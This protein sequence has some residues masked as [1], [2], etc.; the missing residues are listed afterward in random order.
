MVFRL[1]V[2][3]DEKRCSLCKCNTCSFNKNFE[4]DFCAKYRFYEYPH[5]CENVVEFCK[6][7]SENLFNGEVINIENHFHN[8]GNI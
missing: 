5:W 8:F 1:K 2:S 7:Y 3:A 6:N 4:C